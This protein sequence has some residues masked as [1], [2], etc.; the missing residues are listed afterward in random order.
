M[1]LIAACL[2]TG[3]CKELAHL[4]HE[5]QMEVL[6][7]IHEESEL[8][9]LNPHIDMVGVNNRHLGTFHTDVSTSFQLAKLLPEELT[10]VSESGLSQPETVKQL[11]EAGFHGFLMGEAF[12]KSPRPGEALYNFIQALQV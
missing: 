11:R 5:L 8:D 6:L 4:A 2:T 3:Q 1:L 12:M 7:E 9:H 10:R